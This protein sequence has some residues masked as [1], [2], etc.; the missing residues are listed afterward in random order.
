MAQRLLEG[1]SQV[2]GHC[3]GLQGEWDRRTLWVGFKVE[4][5]ALSLGGAISITD[6]D[7]VGTG[8]CRS[9]QKGQ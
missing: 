8:S 2:P 4:R 1:S 7:G 5:E 3:S 9:P 6:R